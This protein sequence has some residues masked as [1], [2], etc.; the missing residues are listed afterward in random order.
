MAVGGVTGAMAISAQ[1]ISFDLTTVAIALTVQQ[2]ATIVVVGL[3]PLMFRDPVE[4][5]NTLLL[6]GAVA[7]LAGS[8]VVVLAGR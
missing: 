6:G 8:A 7:M 5:I 4:R 3:T 1:W 2:L